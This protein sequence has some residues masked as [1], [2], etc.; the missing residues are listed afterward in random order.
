M[1]RLSFALTA[2]LSAAAGVLLL[3][4]AIAAVVAYDQLA[5]Q[6]A[7]ADAPPSPLEATLAIAAV[8]P[9]HPAESEP[10]P[11]PVTFDTTGTYT[12]PIAGDPARW[13]WTH[14]HWDGTHAA[15][16]EAHPALSYPDFVDATN[17]TLVAVTGGVLVDYSGSVGGQGYMLHGDDGLDYYYAHMA[18]Q[19]L[20]D[21]A[22]VAP[23]QPLGIVGNTGNTA[24]FIEPHLHLAIGPRDS[25]WAQQPGINAAEWIQSHFGLPWDER[26]SHAVPFDT[27]HGPPVVHPDVAILTPF[28]EATTAGLA[29]P[30]IELGFTAAPPGDQDIIA[31]LSGTINVIRW[32]VHYGTR[33]QITNDAAQITAVIS[34]V[35]G[36]LVTD[37]EAVQ[38][39]QVIGRWNPASRPRLHY[40]IFENGAIIDPTPSLGLSRAT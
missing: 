5:P 11:A 27:P 23:G 10:D 13:I 7:P 36:W 19:W 9:E 34:G 6:R 37:G 1:P 25:L 14:L 12:F 4:L 21:G 32:T 33:I 18:E 31:P 26:P 3:L 8:A 16:I 39:G 22:R 40:M 15:D 28:E 35:D 20:P 24:Q 30:A 38:A 29:E 17:S 2:A